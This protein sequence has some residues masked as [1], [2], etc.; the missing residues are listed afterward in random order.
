V[1]ILVASEHASIVGGREVY[2]AAVIRELLVRGHEVAY[3]HERDANAGSGLLTPDGVSAILAS[4]VRETLLRCRD[5]SP[6]VVF[7]NELDDLSL[8]NELIDS[9]PSVA[10]VH[11]Y[12]ATCVSALK[13]FAK[14]R[15]EPCSRRLGLGC[16]ACY[17]PR[18][19]G[20]L[21][22]VT[23]IGLYRG[24]R[25]RLATLRRQDRVVVASRWMLAENERHG[26][27][28]DR[29]RLVPYGVT[30]RRASPRSGGVRVLGRLIF[31]GRLV[32]EKGGP[33]LVLAMAHASKE[34]GRSLELIVAG[35]GPDKP[36]IEA[37]ARE[38]G[39]PARFEGWVGEE[40]R[41]E[42]FD[43]VDALAI[44]S[45]WPE[46]FGLVGI[47][48]AGAGVPA[49]AFGV[50]GITDWLEPGVTGE[51]APGD[52]PAVE[53]LSAA[54]VRALRD[55]ILLARLGN[56]AWSRS[57]RFT[58]GAHVTAL[59]AVLLEARRRRGRGGS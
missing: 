19:C 10:F 32:P 15:P 53:G 8:A 54:I 45:L 52:R 47:E 22:P 28:P 29:L 51:V 3:L 34:L 31:M 36:R 12:G 42:L 35:D 48:A 11:S 4:G 2:L 49:I 1:K 9:F 33:E 40:R 16:L 5:W 59:E 37:A 24:A 27:A 56:E 18:R 7:Q 30:R 14:P 57:S 25:A 38:A 41:A 50:G 44:P 21:N 58:I 46:P 6:E 13:R 26:L 20:G 43:E 17:F 55:P 39:V 23:M